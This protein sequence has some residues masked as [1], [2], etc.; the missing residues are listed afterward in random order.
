MRIK[1]NIII[2]DSIIT[3]IIGTKKGDSIFASANSGIN[4]S[5]SIGAKINAHNNS[6]PY[7]EIKNK[8]LWFRTPLVLILISF[9]AIFVQSL[10]CGRSISNCCFLLILLYIGSW[11][12]LEINVIIYI[13]PP[14]L[15][16]LEFFI[17]FEGF[18]IIS[19]PC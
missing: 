5:K 18:W 14:L 13:C 6:N 8:G 10:F 4:V 15:S 1:K 7:I 19:S 16:I 17:L 9:F 12:S 3:P 2:K 11:F